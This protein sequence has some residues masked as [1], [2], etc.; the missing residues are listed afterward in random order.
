[1]DKYR[2]AVI[3]FLKENTKLDN[4]QIDS[5]IEI[6]PEHKFGDFAFPCFALAKEMKKAPVEIAKELIEK[7]KATKILNEVKAIGPYLNFFVN[8]D[9]L[10]KVKTA[11]MRGESFATVLES[12]ATTLD[13]T[14]AAETSIT[15]DYQHDDIEVERGDL[16]P[17]IT[18]GLRQATIKESKNDL[19]G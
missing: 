12:L 11:K 10:A 7:F 13:L 3:N 4:T 14:G 1:M 5:M 8:K 19:P 2:T 15:F 17:F 6:P 18:I 16:V 9:A